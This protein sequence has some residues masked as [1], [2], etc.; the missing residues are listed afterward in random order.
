MNRKW[1]RQSSTDIWNSVQYRK[2]LLND[3]VGDAIPSLNRAKRTHSYWGYLRT[4]KME[5]RNPKS[6]TTRLHSQLPSK[7][8]ASS[9]HWQPPSSCEFE[10]LDIAK[11]NIGRLEELRR[12]IFKVQPRIVVSREEVQPKEA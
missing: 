3:P 8:S 11:L 5:D 7:M 6:F 2:Q 1:N 12:T 4:K 10:I 9:E